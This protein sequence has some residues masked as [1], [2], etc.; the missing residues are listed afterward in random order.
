MKVNILKC[1]GAQMMSISIFTFLVFHKIMV[2]NCFKLY[3]FFHIFNAI[4]YH[5]FFN[6]YIVTANWL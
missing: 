4:E 2:Y 5:L 1:V 6:M 3:V